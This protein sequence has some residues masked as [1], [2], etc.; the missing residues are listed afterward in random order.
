MKYII[1]TLISFN[2]FAQVNCP[3]AYSEAELQK[4]KVVNRECVC[5]SKVCEDNFGFDKD[6]RLENNKEN[7]DCVQKWMDAKVTAVIYCNLVNKAIY[8][9]SFEVMFEKAVN[10]SSLSEKDIAD[11]HGRV[12]DDLLPKK[13]K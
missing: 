3:S 7:P 5:G 6:Y 8:D 12:L 10:L 2:I 13:C 1:L 4:C 9:E 11:E